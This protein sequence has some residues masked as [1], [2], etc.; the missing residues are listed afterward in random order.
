MGCKK[1]YKCPC[2]GYYTLEDEPGH[3]DICPVCRWE[4]DNIQSFDPDY[5]GGANE[6]NLNDARKNYK[7][8]GAISKDFIDSVRPPTEEEKVGSC[9]PEKNGKDDLVKPN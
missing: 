5:W 4:D 3:F 7:E 6:M 2:C 8:L 1:K 9:S